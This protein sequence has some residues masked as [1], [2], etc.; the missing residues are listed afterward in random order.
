MMICC[1]QSR[2]LSPIESINKHKCVKN[3][4]SSL[5]SPHLPSIIIFACEFEISIP[6]Y[7]FFVYYRVQISNN[8]CHSIVLSLEFQVDIMTKSKILVGY[9]VDIDAVAGWL[10]SYGGE[11]STSDISRGISIFFSSCFP[12]PQCLALLVVSRDP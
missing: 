10:G 6:I 12:V 3:F 5:P 7:T 1:L 8:Y 4:P 11:D 9:G 2:E